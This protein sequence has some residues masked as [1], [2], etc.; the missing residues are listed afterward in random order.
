VAR[1]H[2]IENLPSWEDI[3]RLKR[4]AEVLEKIRLLL[5]RQAIAV[6]SGYRCPQLNRW[7]GGVANSAHLY[8]HAA[9]FVCPGFG[10]P[11]AICAHLRPH[12][13]TLGI[14]QLIDESGWVHVGLR[15]GEPRHQCFKV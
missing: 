6:S 13:A 14:D 11:T 5:D 7:V 4:L 10:S 15:D 1:Q 2:G 12:L 9:D 3:E 8:G